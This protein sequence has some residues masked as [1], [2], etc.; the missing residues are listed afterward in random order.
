[1][2]VIILLIRQIS[3]MFVMIFFGFLSAKCNLLH[4][5]ESKYLS[6]MVLY[7]IIPCILIHSFQIEVTES[8]YHGMKTA[9]VGSALVNLVFLFLTF[10][11]RKVLKLKPV[12]AASL[13]YP[14][15]GNLIIPI[16]GAVLGEEWIVYCCAFVIIQNLLLWT[17]G[18]YLISGEKKIS[19]REMFLNSSM[20]AIAAGF[21]L[22]VTGIK[23]PGIL[24]EAAASTG[25]AVAPVSM[26][27]AG[28]IIGDM[29]LKEV[30]RK[31]KAYLVCA[32]RLLF[33]PAVIIGLFLGLGIFGFGKGEEQVL[34]VVLLAAAAPAA[35]NVVQFAQI[36]S[37]DA[38]DACIINVM[39][40]IFSIAT[41]PFVVAVY[42]AL[43]GTL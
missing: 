11:G 41:M 20:L 21:V 13:L 26:F 5:K 29:N 18:K 34:L 43:S 23:L 24:Q 31:K 19:F 3:V 40:T 6:K 22:M 1:M 28:V 12:E 35:S 37:E 38:S 42:Q 33:Y 27:I 15:S 39:S 32:L 4:T 36:Y 30:F 14:N 2:D 8:T 9:F 10:A 25:N 17:Y 16:V 7:V